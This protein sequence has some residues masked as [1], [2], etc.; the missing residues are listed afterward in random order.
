[1]EQRQIGNT[2]VR[3]SVVGLGG[4][5]LGDSV[6]DPG[7][8]SR[9]ISVLQAAGEAGINWVDTSENYFDT[10]NESVIGAACRELSEDFLI[11]SKVAPGALKSGGSSTS[12]ETSVRRG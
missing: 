2:D 7:D 10:G 11:C 1:M 5:W 9:A 8:V 12:V 3:L 4:A 6:E